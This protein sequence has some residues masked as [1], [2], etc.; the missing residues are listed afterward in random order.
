MKKWHWIFL[1]AAVGAVGGIVF[2][3]ATLPDGQAFSPVLAVIGAVMGVMAAVMLGGLA[4]FVVS[5][6][7]AP[8][9]VP[10]E[11]GESVLHE[12]PANRVARA[13]ADG[14]TLRFTDRRLVFCP[15]RFATRRE[16]TAIEWARV[17]HLMLDESVL[18]Q[19]GKA[20][21]KVAG[22]MAHVRTRVPNSKILAV[23]CGESEL[24]FV[25]I[26]SPELEGLLA[27]LVSP[28]RDGM[29]P[30]AAPGI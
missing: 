8:P 12:L 6:F 13:A 30:A 26:P 18:L 14:G 15:N 25:V 19:L 9:T 23:G 17:E 28:K 10:L 27:R 16:T 7:R 20:A 29:Q 5:A 22:S 3:R 2:V 21:M 24:R 11:Q 4:W 1:G